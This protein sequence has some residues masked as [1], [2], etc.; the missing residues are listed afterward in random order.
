MPAL[1][2][3][4]TIWL[5]VI[6]QGI[7]QRGRYAVLRRGPPVVRLAA[8]RSGLLVRPSLNPRYQHPVPLL[9]S[10]HGHVQDCISLRA[11]P[12]PEGRTEEVE[13]V[14]CRV[15]HAVAHGGIGVLPVGVMEA[16]TAAALHVDIF[17]LLRAG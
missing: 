4:A 5:N 14:G 15:K 12:F 16:D 2:N 1:S 6:G 9:L 11:W 17:S 13:R 8:V 3:R 10:H 7:E